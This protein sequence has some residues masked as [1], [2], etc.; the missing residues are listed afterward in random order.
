MSPQCCPQ[1]SSKTRLPPLEPDCQVE[2]P[3]VPAAPRTPTPRAH[4]DSADQSFLPPDMLPGRELCGAVSPVCPSPAAGPGR[5]PGAYIR[6]PP[7][8]AR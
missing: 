6:R 7:R 5:S 1:R 4:L 2:D 3:K 8:A